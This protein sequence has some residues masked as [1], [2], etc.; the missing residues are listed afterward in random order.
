MKGLGRLNFGDIE[1][2][3]IKAI[4]T[5]NIPLTIQAW[6]E[7]G[8]PAQVDTAELNNFFHKTALA[9][10]R[11]M[12]DWFAEYDT[13]FD[14]RTKIIFLL[15]DW[16]SNPGTFNTHRQACSLTWVTNRPFPLVYAEVRDYQEFDEEVSI[17]EI[18]GWFD[19][20]AEEFI[21]IFNPDSPPEEY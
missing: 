20:H 9:L 12:N 11:S 17:F 6:I 7:L 5:G 2:E 16:Q 1:D 13:D 4:V 14:E 21:D 3:L 10:R 19:K 8:G 18:R 15:S